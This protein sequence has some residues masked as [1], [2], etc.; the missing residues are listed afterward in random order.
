[1]WDFMEALNASGIQTDSLAPLNHTN[2][3]NFANQLDK[4]LRKT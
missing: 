2:R 1:M 3:K 4:M